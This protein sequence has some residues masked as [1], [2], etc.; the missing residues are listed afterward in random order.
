MKVLFDHNVPHKLRRSMIAHEVKM[1]DEM[2][3]AELGNGDLLRAAERAGFA[4]M[5][6]GD[7]NLSFQQNLRLVELAL[8]AQHE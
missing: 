7:K 6:T 4:L 1:A 3:W 5:V 2:G 8:V